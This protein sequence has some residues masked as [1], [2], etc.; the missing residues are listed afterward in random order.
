[1]G[2]NLSDLVWMHAL[3]FTS[4]FQS[5]FHWISSLYVSCS[6]LFN[7][8]FFH[9][10]F[11]ILL[12]LLRNGQELFISIWIVSNWINRH[13]CMMAC[14]EANYRLFSKLS[15]QEIRFTLGTYFLVYLRFTSNFTQNWTGN[16]FIFILYVCIFFSKMN[17]R[18]LSGVSFP[19]FPTLR[20]KENLNSNQ[21]KRNLR[22]WISLEQ[23]HVFTCNLFW[24]VF[25]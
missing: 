18:L 19:F 8:I 23:Q 24:F 10:I 25:H 3:K 1:M 4:S 14:F 21:V 7:I 6:Y 15:V 11:E 20:K 9:P 17:F 16:E 2:F 13:Q 12:S 22:R 5:F